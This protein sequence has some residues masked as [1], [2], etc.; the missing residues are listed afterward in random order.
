MRCL[1]M[2]WPVAARKSRL[3]WV[4]D[5]FSVLARSCRCEAAGRRPPHRAI[6]GEWPPRVTNGDGVASRGAPWPGGRLRRAARPAVHDAPRRAVTR[7]RRRPATHP[8]RGAVGD[9]LAPEAV[10]VLETLDSELD[11]MSGERNAELWTTEGLRESDRWRLI[12]DLARRALS[13]LPERL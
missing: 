4:T 6:C 12:R 13:L 5:T 9:I 11:A 2:V 1:A 7:L 10:D 3:R 8:W